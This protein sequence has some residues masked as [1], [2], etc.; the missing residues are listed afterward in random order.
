[1]ALA[2]CS[3]GR[4]RCPT[5][6]RRARD[7]IGSPGPDR[8][9]CTRDADQASIRRQIALR[10]A[11][12]PASGPTLKAIVAGGRI[13]PGQPS[14]TLCP[15]AIAERL[16]VPLAQIS[17]DALSLVGAFTLRRRG[18]EAKLV[19]ANPPAALDHTLVKTIALGRTWFEEIKAGATMQAIANREGVA[20]AASLISSILP[21]WRPT[22]CAR[23]SRV[24]SPRR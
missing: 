5:D 23:S 14:V 11:E 22:W 6:R 21:S 3:T 18:V 12:R 15:E 9:R 1:M 20:N 10:S 19:L 16:G 7:A 13:E 2:G 8:W 24:A 4:R 17:R